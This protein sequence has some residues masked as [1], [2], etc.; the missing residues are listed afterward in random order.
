M[1]PQ[2]QISKRWLTVGDIS[3]DDQCHAG[4][5]C[6]ITALI[7]IAVEVT[8]LADSAYMFG[9]LTNRICLTSYCHHQT[10]VAFA[11]Q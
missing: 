10:Q 4:F 6:G 5:L 9:G 7:D 1:Q 2:T 3:A 11:E 8:R